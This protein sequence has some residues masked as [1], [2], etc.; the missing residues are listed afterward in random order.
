M[1]NGGPPENVMQ[2]LEACCP[3]DVVPKVLAF[4]GPQMTATLM[5]TNR[6]W[7]QLIAR[8]DGT[9]RSLCEGMYKVSVIN[10]S[11]QQRQKAVHFM[12]YSHLLAGF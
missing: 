3:N 9:W 5:A 8:D 7:F 10:C 12:P 11:R 6:Y 2:W 1:I 4:C